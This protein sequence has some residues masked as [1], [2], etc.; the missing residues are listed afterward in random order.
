MAIRWW[1]ALIVTVSVGGTGLWLANGVPGFSPDMLLIPRSLF[2]IPAI[3]LLPPPPAAS[4]EPAPRPPPAPSPPPS[5]P[6][7]ISLVTP[8]AEP[9]SG[10]AT[11]PQSG[12]S[13]LP[14]VVRPSG[15]VA[16]SAAGQT[17]FAVTTLP[18]VIRPTNPGQPS[19]ASGTGFFVSSDGSIMTAAHVVRQC[20]NIEISS[21]YVRT[22]TARVLAIDTKNDIAVL[23]A[24]NVK[25]PAVIGLAD[26][27]F[28]PTHLEIFGYPGDAD[29][30]VPT[31][32]GGAY[33]PERPNF[34]GV[35]RRDLIWIDSNPV[36]P[37]FSGGPVYEPSG[38]AIGLIN[39]HV[40][41]RSIRNGV[42]L[43]DTKYVFGAS[44]RMINRFLSEE[45]PSLVL[46]GGRVSNA[47][48][49]DKGVVRILCV[50]K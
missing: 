35:D 19:A 26:R 36:R 4:R 38:D 40:M 47:S 49:L 14:E 20:D 29:Q 45:V 43:R 17:T 2:N 10:P 50:H 32:V 37:G 9:S 1:E 16:G 22:A 48:R 24:A 8:A 18:N 11:A 5:D 30:A 21:K 15:A 25:P 23:R 34:E 41:V 13:R 6:R 12:G 39:G 3:P 28:G 33:R 44:T 7:V 27:P 42:T 31:D 46:D